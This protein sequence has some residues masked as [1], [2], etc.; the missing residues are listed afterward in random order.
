MFSF[1]PSHPFFISFSSLQLSLSPIHHTLSPSQSQSLPLPLHSTIR[2]RCDRLST[3]L[4]VSAPRCFARLTDRLTLSLSSSPPPSSL[5]ARACP[6]ALLCFALLC[7][8]KTRNRTQE[9]IRTAAAAAA[10]THASVLSPTSLPPSMP[11]H[12]HRFVHPR[13][14]KN[15]SSCITSSAIA[16]SALLCCFGCCCCCRL[17]ILITPRAHAGICCSLYRGPLRPAIPDFLTRLLLSQFQISSAIATALPHS[18]FALR[19]YFRF[20]VLPVASKT[21]P[22]A[23]LSRH[24][25][26]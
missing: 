1:S 10:A 26:H 25:Q 13:K 11:P 3:I 17:C 4:L 6:P 15:N 16:S 24:R 23:V 14:N 8:W 18:L 7:H 12:H 20:S 21:Q 9:S 19:R 5:S 22:R 2:Q